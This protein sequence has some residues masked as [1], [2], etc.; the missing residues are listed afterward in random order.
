VNNSGSKLKIRLTGPLGNLLLFPSMGRE[1]CES[2][3]PRRKVVNN[4][5]T[6]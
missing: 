2:T 5:C 1:T 4:N 6:I 3:Y